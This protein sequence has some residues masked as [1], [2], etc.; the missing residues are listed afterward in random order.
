MTRPIIGEALKT[1]VAGRDLTR[2]AAAAMEAILSG[3]ATNAQIA[4]F[5][6]APRPPEQG[7]APAHA[8]YQAPAGAPRGRGRWETSAVTA[9]RGRAGLVSSAS[10]P[11]RRRPKVATAPARP[12]RAARAG[13][14][15]GVRGHCPPPRVGLV[16][17]G[18]LQ[19]RN[20]S[21]Q[22]VRA[23]GGRAGRIPPGS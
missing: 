7:L 3:A 21:P 6:G 16:Q 23:S 17:P 14:V 5:L 2:I 4:A 19:A 11:P 1:L 18:A 22:A 13:L 9:R 15:R 20:P 8:T 12:R 10:P